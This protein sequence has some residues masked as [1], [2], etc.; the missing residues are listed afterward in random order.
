ML[1]KYSSICDPSIFSQYIYHSNNNNNPSG[2]AAFHRMTV[3]GPWPLHPIG[4]RLKKGLDDSIP[5][6]FMYGQNTW[7][8]NIYAKL[9]KDQR[10]N[11]KLIIVEGAGHHIYTDNAPEFN[12]IVLEACRVLRSAQEWNHDKSSVLYDIW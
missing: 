1:E 9:I 12:R 8:N 2:E 4:E 3:V 7:I 6:T 5:V 11:A 10:K